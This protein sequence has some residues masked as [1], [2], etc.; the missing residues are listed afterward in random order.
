MSDTCKPLV[1]IVIPVYN[2]SNFLAQ[3]IDSALAQTYENVE[4][5]VVN[6][7]SRDGGKTRDVAR[8]YGEK[9]RY[10]EK[11]NGGVATA[12]NFGIRQ[13]RGA[14][15]SWLSHDDLYDP[16]KLELQIAAAGQFAEPVV[17]YSNATVFSATGRDVCHRIARQANA[18]MRCFLA[19]DVTTGLNGCSLLVPRTFFESYGAF[20]PAL[21]F[22]QDYDLWFRL[23]KHV[24]FVGVEEPLVRSRSHPEQD[25]RQ[26]AAECTTMADE[27]HAGMVR[28]I[29]DD[30]LRRFV[31]ENLDYV[32]HSYRTYATAGYFKT[33]AAMLGAILRH[34]EAADA[35]RLR[36]EVVEGSLQCPG[37]DV[38]AFFPNRG[39]C[40]ASAKRRILFYSN[41]FAVGGIERAIS[42]VAG[43]LQDDY[44]ILLV[45][46]EHDRDAACPLPKRVRHL[47]I[48]NGG[49]ET[50]PQ[51][52][53]LLSVALEIDLF[54]GCPNLNERFLDVYPLLHGAG[55]K[56]IAW[57]H[58][59]YF[60]P[61]DRDWWMPEVACKRNE[62]YRSVS[63]ALWLTSF[64]AGIYSGIHPNG[65]LMPNPTPFPDTPDPVEVRD[66][67]E[68]IVLAVGRFY[69][70]IKRI[71]LMLEVFRRVLDAAP[72]AKLLLVGDYDLNARVPRDSKKTI[73]ERL[74]ELC[75]DES[76]VIFT[77]ETD[78]VRDYYR[79]A[80]ILMM[81]SDSEGFPMV[82]LEAAHQ[83]VPAVLFEI[84][85][86]EDVIEQGKNGYFVPR[87]DLDGMAARIVAVLSDAGLRRELG[88]NA[89]AMSRR[90]AP[91]IVGGRWKRL[92]AA[93]LE[94]QDEAELHALLARDFAPRIDDRATF[95]RQVVGCYER[96]VQGIVQAGK[97]GEG[98]AGLALCGHVGG[99]AL[100][101]Q[102][103][104]RGI[105]RRL[106]KV[107]LVR[108]VYYRLYSP[109]VRP[110]LR[111]GK[112]A[113][114]QFRARGPHWRKSAV[115]AAPVNE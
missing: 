14:W 51:R 35:R 96:R 4:V 84:P 33:A 41:I 29:A 104:V 85:G 75:L 19:F 110:I 13:M 79:K 82:L 102:I 64:A 27:L 67:P 86:L 68:K 69:D 44:E 8:S 5:I 28:S 115:R 9:I 50:I 73:R 66:R 65:A 114:A 76:R 112:G 49:F 17:V 7:G 108:F 111:R 54:V 89:Q 101:G 36:R 43:Q 38:E 12:L 25:C 113:I 30:E 20:D 92:I 10:F 1:S 55:V 62:V 32:L 15:F 107:G 11:E 42:G 60:L 71:D 23:A 87:D 72:D 21:R 6:D 40:G 24:P 57:N 47:K 45:S 16:R 80:S 106:K 81:T 2:G 97:D 93:V 31:R 100:I 53:T 88:Q 48:L 83:G 34:A 39:A 37:Q 95:F 70:S 61:L 58:Y 26:K 74:A 18:S 90:F 99:L 94:S 22:T 3:A 52:L 105:R 103:L 78:N 98:R 109:H 56:S 91:E 46:G 77:G 59:F 63:A